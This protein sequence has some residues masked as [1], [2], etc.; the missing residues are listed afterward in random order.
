MG[1]ASSSIQSSVADEDVAPEIEIT[2][3]MIDAA[4][5]VLLRYDQL[6]DSLYDT[7]KRVL[8]SAF[9]ARLSPRL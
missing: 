1:L 5:E 7:A 4:C 9:E 3:E 2:P 8:A 6:E